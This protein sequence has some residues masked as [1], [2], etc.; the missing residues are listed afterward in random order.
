MSEYKYTQFKKP[1]KILLIIAVILV[2]LNLRPSIT[3]VGPIIDLLRESLLLSNFS[4]GILTSL[5]LIA[6]GIMSPIVPMISMRFTNEITLIAG[7]VI[8]VLGLV[9]RS[10]A[11]VPLLFIGTILIGIGIAIA[12]V[13]LPGIIKE[14]FPNRVPMMTSVYVTA[15]SLF[16]ALASGVSLP[17][18]NGLDWGWE[19]ALGVWIIPAVMAIIIWFY[20][21]KNRK[22]ADDVQLYY[23][24]ADNVRM[25]RS[26][27][28]WQVAIFFGLQAFAYNALMTWLPE[29]LSDYGVTSATGGWMLSFN[30]LVGLPI[31]LFIPII[32]GKLKSQRSLI[33]VL[34]A[35][36]F[37]GYLGLLIGGSYN[38]ML[39]SV[40]LLGLAYG[41]LF[42]LSLLFLGMRARTALEAG[43]LSGMAQAV[44][45]LLA[46]IGPILLGTLVDLSGAW[47]YSL[48]ALVL[49]TVLTALV[50]LGAGRDLVVTEDIKKRYEDY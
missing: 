17:I 34:C 46:A 5:P 48:Y 16:A 45:Y 1:D 39:V 14:R 8:L 2:A 42:P 18:A 49:V 33:L 12:N 30:Q 24:K 13:L 31:S 40:T 11:F 23:V 15:M 29:I 3:S 25:W 10:L 50:G 7:M 35:F 44:G 9:I 37:I 41:G 43:Q 47:T 6:F 22:S 19:G 38:M 26:P 27:L 28:A 20:F 21:V 36:A 4:I 32:A